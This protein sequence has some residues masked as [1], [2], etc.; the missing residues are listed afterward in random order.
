[1]AWVILVLAGLFEVGWAIGLKY[2]EGFTR[3][4]PTHVDGPSDDHQ[5]LATGRCCEV[6]IRRHCIQHLGGGWSGRHRHPRN[7][8]AW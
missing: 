4:W 2:T 5:P 3:L 8:A 1:M 7:R 6:T